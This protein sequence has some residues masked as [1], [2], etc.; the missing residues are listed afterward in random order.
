M[1]FEFA[2]NLET[3]KSSNLP[4]SSVG[5]STVYNSYNDQP[6]ISYMEHNWIYSTSLAGAIQATK[7]KM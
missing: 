6:R 1:S 5:N 7:C 4:K 2:Y 3:E